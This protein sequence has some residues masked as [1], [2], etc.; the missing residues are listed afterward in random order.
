M[1]DA[2]QGTTDY[3]T[4]SSS[5]SP[6]AESGKD[7]LSP[8]AIASYNCIAAAQVVIFQHAS[9]EACG[10]SHVLVDDGEKAQKRVD[11]D[12]MEFSTCK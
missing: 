12:Y 7:F 6:D 8:L 3:G 4:I 5:H 2:D 11:R 10:P 1:G 9:F